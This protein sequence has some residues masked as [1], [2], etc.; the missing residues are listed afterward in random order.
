[1]DTLGSDRLLLR[2]FRES[3]LDAYAAMCGDP[4]VMRYLGD[5]LS[6]DRDRVLAEHGDWSWATGNCADSACGPWRSGDRASGRPGRLLAARKDGRAWKLAGP[7]AE[8]SGAAAMR[9]RPRSWCSPMPFSRRTDRAD[10]PD[11]S[12]KWTLDRGRA[13]VWACAGNKIP[14]SWV[15]PPDLRNRSPRQPGS[16]GAAEP[17]LCRIEPQTW[18]RKMTMNSLNSVY[19]SDIGCFIILR[20]VGNRMSACRGF[21][22]N[23]IAA[24][25]AFPSTGPP[26]RPFGYDPESDQMGRDTLVSGD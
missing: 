14:K 25:L 10:Q 1:M 23:L 19:P 2:M 20:T 7:C 18:I 22:R 15:I 12:P 16:D 21:A 5:G 3:D 24:A 17:A 8:S 6:A 13:A 4:E 9:P 26:G 11:P